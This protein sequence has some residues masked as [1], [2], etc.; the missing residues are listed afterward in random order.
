MTWSIWKSEANSWAKAVPTIFK[1]VISQVYKMELAVVRVSV[2][3][4]MKMGIYRPFWVIYKVSM[5]RIWKFEMGPM[6]IA[7]K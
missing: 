2:T 5:V 6:H 4:L 1:C 3:G 7:H